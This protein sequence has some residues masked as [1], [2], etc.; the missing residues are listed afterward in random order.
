M[1][2]GQPCADVLCAFPPIAAGLQIGEFV[3]RY[4]GFRESGAAAML[5]TNIHE[6]FSPR[7]G[8]TPGTSRPLTICEILVV[9]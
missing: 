6:F 8:F 4:Q 5:K 2:V 9:E 1:W 7:V 3:R